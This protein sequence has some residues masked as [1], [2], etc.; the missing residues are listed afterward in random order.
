M[1]RARLQALALGVRLQ[2]CISKNPGRILRAVQTKAIAS[3][4]PRARALPWVVVTI[5]A[6][7]VPIQFWDHPGERSPWFR[8]EWLAA[9]LLCVSLTS[10]VA[11]LR[12][13]SRRAKRVL[14]ILQGVSAVALSVIIF[15]RLLRH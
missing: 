3:T 2:A 12:T 13:D 10:L 15:S 14:L 6:L 11:G 4:S 8:S 1:A 5:A 7:N 9:L